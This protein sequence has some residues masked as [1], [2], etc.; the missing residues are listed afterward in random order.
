MEGEQKDLEVPKDKDVGSPMTP[1]EFQEALDTLFE[2]AK[3]DGVKPIQEMA[4][5]YATK[6]LNIFNRVLAALEEE[7]DERKKKK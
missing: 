5:T 4:R 6:G 7:Y 3:A 1:Q 2:R